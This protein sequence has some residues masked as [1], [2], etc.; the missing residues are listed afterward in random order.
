MHTTK[1][2]RLHTIIICFVTIMAATTSAFA[3]EDSRA[4]GGAGRSLVLPEEPIKGRRP[5]P[6]VKLVMQRNARAVRATLDAITS[7]RL[8][9]LRV[10]RG[11]VASLP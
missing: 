1:T 2:R 11:A 9:A 5:M 3:D 8:D 6:A 4:R 7:D 10:R